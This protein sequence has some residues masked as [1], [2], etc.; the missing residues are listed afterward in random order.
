M[1]LGIVPVTIVTV[2]PFLY[3]STPSQLYNIDCY[4][5]VLRG[6]CREG[7]CVSVDI[8]GLVSSCG[9]C[10]SR[11]STYVSM[12]KTIMIKPTSEIGFVRSQAF[13]KFMGFL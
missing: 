7:E 6:N 5:V 12:L 8:G 13:I 2:N 3:V 10:K 11:L 1:W 9:G 4:I